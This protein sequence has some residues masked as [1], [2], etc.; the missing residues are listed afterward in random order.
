MEFKDCARDGIGGEMDGIFRGE[1]CV[2]YQGEDSGE[3]Y[4]VEESYPCFGLRT[5]SDERKEIIIIN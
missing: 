2:C 5:L 4:P 3:I 1:L